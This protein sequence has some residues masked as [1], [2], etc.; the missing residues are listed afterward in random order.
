MKRVKS[1]SQIPSVPSEV[2]TLEAPLLNKQHSK[3]E[4]L[5]ELP[6]IHKVSSLLS[7]HYKE[8]LNKLK[9]DTREL[10][11]ILKEIQDF[12]DFVKAKAEGF[13][14]VQIQER[15]LSHPKLNPTSSLSVDDPNKSKESMLGNVNSKKTHVQ[16]LSRSKTEL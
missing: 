2:N 7:F 3:E 14:V 11:D 13:S 4:Y 10:E 15:L 16:F 6:K 9:L 1:V 8:D 12:K 5:S